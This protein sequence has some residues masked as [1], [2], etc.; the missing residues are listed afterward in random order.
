MASLPSFPHPFPVI[1]TASRS[2]RL[3]LLLTLILCRFF[4]HYISSARLLLSWCLLLGD[5]NTGVKVRQGLNPTPATYVEPVFPRLWASVSSD[6]KQG[7]WNISSPRVLPA[8]VYTRISLVRIHGVNVLGR[9]SSTQALFREAASA[10]PLT[11][12]VSV[13]SSFPGLPHQAH[14]TGL[15]L[16]VFSSVSPRGAVGATRVPPVPGEGLGFLFT[17]AKCLKNVHN[18][19]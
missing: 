14:H 13:R 2:A 19:W 11:R 17:S 6:V 15:Q 16:P 7:S 10:E 8:Q 12:R 5:T 3:I 18:E 9:W 1:R 4:P